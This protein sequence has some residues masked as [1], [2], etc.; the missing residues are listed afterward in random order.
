LALRNEKAPS[1]IPEGA[2][3]VPRFLLSGTGHLVGACRCKHLRMV[4]MVMMVM[5]VMIHVRFHNL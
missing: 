4:M 1:G 5:A 2:S 3:G